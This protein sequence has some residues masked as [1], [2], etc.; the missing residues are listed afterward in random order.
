MLIDLPDLIK[1]YLTNFHYRFDNI[2]PH[3]QYPFLAFPISRATNMSSRA[4]PIRITV[5]EFI[6]GLP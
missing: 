1:D 2:S 3:K 6:P 4:Q 5:G